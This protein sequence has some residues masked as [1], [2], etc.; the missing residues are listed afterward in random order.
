VRESQIP[1]DISLLRQLVD[2]GYVVGT[3]P[4]DYDVSELKEE[5][6]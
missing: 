1:D 6:D 2:Q 4:Q 5:A 3:P